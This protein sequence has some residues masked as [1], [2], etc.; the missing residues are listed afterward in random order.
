MVRVPSESVHEHHR[1]PRLPRARVPDGASPPGPVS[2]RH[3]VPLPRRV[4]RSR[5]G[6][7]RHLHRRASFTLASRAR[8]SRRRVDASL[9]PD[10][11]V[12]AFAR[13]HRARRHRARRHRARSRCAVPTMGRDGSASKGAASRERARQALSGDSSATSSFSGCASNARGWTRGGRTRAIVDARAGHFS[14]G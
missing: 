8:A 13:R 9:T 14:I 11:I 1:L 6:R 2:L 12:R 5:G 4:A 7:R 3:A 10:D